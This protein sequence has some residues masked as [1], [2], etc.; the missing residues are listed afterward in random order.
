MVTSLKQIKFSLQDILGKLDWKTEQLHGSPPSLK[1]SGLS[2]L[3]ILVNE[4]DSLGLFDTIVD[5]IKQ[6]AIFTSSNDQMNIQQSEGN[7][8][9]YNL[10]QLKLLLANFLNLLLKTVP[11]ESVDSIN[12]KLPPVNDFDE[13]SKVSRD[14]HIA[15]SQIVYNEEVGGHTK[16]VSVENGSI[17]LNVL[18]GTTAVSIIA[19]VVWS[20][21]VIYKKIQEGRL[22]EQ[23]IKSL[24]V[25][26][27]SLDDI[28]KAQKAQTE[29]MI[30]AEA[31]HIQTE[32]FSGNVPENIERIK[33]S[34]SIFANLIEKGA[35]IHPAL[36]APENVSNLFPDP[37]K[38][39]GLESKIK[40]IGNVSEN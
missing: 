40:K 5:V 38:L 22:L 17:W 37:T 16:I 10:N 11:E 21:A 28:L 8:L 35:E 2:N 3:R 36:V 14:I 30:Q 24:K 26:N 27:E 20:A 32:N 12:I 31:E 15:L 4:V 6:S 19:S 18:I 9:I 23:Q 29:I 7:T 1:F 34:I 25:K 13:L 33:N 39:I